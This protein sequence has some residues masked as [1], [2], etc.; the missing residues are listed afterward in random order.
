M[1]GSPADRA[2]RVCRDMQA[3]SAEALVVSRIPGASHCAWEG[4]IIGQ[5][6]R[7]RLGVPVVEV[8]V[9]PLTDSIEPSVRTR[10]EALVETVKGG[11]QQ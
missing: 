2:A 5:M 6:I 4:A 7:Q 11:R 8:E 3:F 9:P 1:A 10:L